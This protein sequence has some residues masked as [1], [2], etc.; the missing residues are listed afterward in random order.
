MN[1]NV[2]CIE[3]NLTSDIPEKDWVLFSA[4]FVRCFS[5]I[6][7]IFCIVSLTYGKT[8]YLTSVSNYILEKAF[9]TYFV[10]DYEKRDRLWISNLINFI[11]ISFSAAISWA[12]ILC[13][14]VK[15]CQF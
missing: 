11:S 1:I 15:I 5:V 2:I 12:L 10:M 4:S 7:T 14:F 13:K 8:M 9:A 3:N 6:H